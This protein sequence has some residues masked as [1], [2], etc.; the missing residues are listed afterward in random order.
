LVAIRKINSKVLEWFLVV[1]GVVLGIVFNN[2][3]WIGYLPILANLQYTLAI[4]KYKD[5][6]R[7]V[8]ISFAICVV[9]FAIFNIIIKNYVG[10]FSNLVILVTT[11]VAVLRKKKV[12][13]A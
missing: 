8:K 3:G 13:E 11:L 2:L 10:F 5:N 12:E 4:F 6:E 7:A 9:L 1:L